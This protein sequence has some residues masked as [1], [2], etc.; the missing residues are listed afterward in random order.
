[1]RT[2]PFF[3]QLLHACAQS[4]AN[5]SGF[6]MVAGQRPFTYHRVERAG[7]VILVEG[8]LRPN[9]YVVTI[10]VKAVSNLDVGNAEGVSCLIRVVVIANEHLVT[11]IVVK[12]SIQETLAHLAVSDQ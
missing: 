11:P 6:Q 1:M 9:R 2:A 7:S 4:D 8:V 12:A 3:G 5:G 10:F